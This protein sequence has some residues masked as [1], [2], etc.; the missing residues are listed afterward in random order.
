[1]EKKFYLCYIDNDTN[2]A[3]FTSDWD[4]QSGDDWN[5]RPYD[6]NAGTPYE[7]NYNAPEQ[8]AENGRGIYPTIE[9]KKLVF[10][11]NDRWDV[12][13]PYESGNFSVDDI[14]RGVIAWLWGENFTIPAKTE[15]ENFIKIVEENGGTIYLPKEVD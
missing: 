9:H 4:N 1:M 5:D 15:Y 12:H 6:C 7:H 10:E 14:N 8:G 11:F 2:K 3:Y 13:Q